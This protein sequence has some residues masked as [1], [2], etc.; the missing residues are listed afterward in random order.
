MFLPP[1][2]IPE[3]TVFILSLHSYVRPLD[4][5]LENVSMAK[6][7]TLIRCPVNNDAISLPSRDD[8]AASLEG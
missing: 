1:R 5:K 7:T 8:A 6:E 3:T 2:T 4:S